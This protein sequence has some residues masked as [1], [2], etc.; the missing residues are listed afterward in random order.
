MIVDYIPP[1]KLPHIVVWLDWNFYAY[2][3]SIMVSIAIM[4]SHYLVRCG[5]HGYTVSA[6]GYAV[7]VLC[8]VCL[9]CVYCAVFHGYAVG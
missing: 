3:P 2:W 8:G 6:G 4:T 7:A 9:W 1:E 5:A